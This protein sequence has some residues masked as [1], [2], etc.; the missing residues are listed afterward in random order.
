MHV[1]VQLWLSLGEE[2][3]PSVVDF[4]KTLMIMLEEVPIQPRLG[5]FKDSLL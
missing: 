4:T 3:Y 5:A 2:E 1:L